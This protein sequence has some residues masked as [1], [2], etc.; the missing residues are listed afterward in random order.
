[1]QA[2]ANGKTEDEIRQ[3]V[4]QVVA[5]KKASVLAECKKHLEASLGRLDTPAQVLNRLAPSSGS[6]GSNIS[7]PSENLNQ[8]G[9]ESKGSD[10]LGLA[11]VAEEFLDKTNPTIEEDISR[12]DQ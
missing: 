9:A 10:N 1:M 4:E 11:I 5:A 7:A 8:E 6:T 2:K 12:R 3:L